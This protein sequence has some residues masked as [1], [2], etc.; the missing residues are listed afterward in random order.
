[1]ALVGAYVLP[2]PPLAVPEV[3]NGNEMQIRRTLDAFDEVAKQ[4]AELEPDSIIFITPHSIIYTDYF[5]ISPGDSAKG[6][7]SD[8]G[9]QKARLDTVYDKNLAEQIAVQA[10]RSGIPA[11]NLGERSPKLDHGLMVPM[12]FINKRYT[13]YKSVRISQSGLDP[14]HHYRFGQCITRAINNTASHTVIVASADLSHKLPGSSYGTVPEGA[15]YDR[16]VT[17]A[18]AKGDFLSIFMIPNSL[19]ERAA[20]C[21]YNSFLMLAGCFD[22]RQVQARLLSYEG[23]FGVGYA[24]ISI[25]P[26]PADDSRDTLRQY[27][28]I[29]LDAAQQSKLEEDAYQTLARQSLEYAVF[30]NKSVMELPAGLPADLLQRRAGVFVSLY[31]DGRLRG[32]IGTI[33]P[34]TTSVAH[35]I[36]QNAVSSGLSDNRF[37]PVEP[38]ELASLVYKVDVLSP[39]EPISSPSEL[40]VA[41]YGVIVTSGMKRGLLLPNLEGVDTVQDQIAI[42]MSKAGIGNNEPVEMERFEVIRHE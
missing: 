39:P 22:R 24:V 18:L 33:M 29:A 31:K 21:G 1:M 42:A 2:H 4:I 26:G 17:E 36:I 15:E 16:K 35:E 8:F 28:E 30:N 19:K 10:E 14:S 6:D 38:S 7:F 11:G 23:P 20:D 3:G 32:C 25:M 40:D 37:D 13:N 12:W 9:A 34:T 41:R 5:H 27:S